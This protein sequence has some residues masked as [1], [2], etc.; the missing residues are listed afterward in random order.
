MIRACMEG[1]AFALRHNLETA[2]EAGAVPMRS[3]SSPTTNFATVRLTPRIETHS[4][5]KCTS[6]PCVVSSTAK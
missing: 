6:K 5:A 4:A 2:A 1:V 3:N